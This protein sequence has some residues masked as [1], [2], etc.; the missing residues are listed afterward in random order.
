MKKAQKKITLHHGSQ[1]NENSVNNTNPMVLSPQSRRSNDYS[2]TFQRQEQLKT[3]YSMNN[4]S[5]SGGFA[6]TPTT[7]MHL[8]SAN[9][10]ALSTHPMNY[11]SYPHQTISE[12]NKS[13]VQ[14][15]QALKS[16]MSE[17]KPGVSSS[18][19]LPMTTSQNL[20]LK[21]KNNDSF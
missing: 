21:K 12:K 7:M 14:T 10:I 15:T 9:D 5:G 20:S 11:P 4:K 8:R 6:Q 19:K 18:I 17:I 1:S 3:E 16:P 13:Q 2:D